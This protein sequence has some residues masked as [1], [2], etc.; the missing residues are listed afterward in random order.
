MA[1]VFGNTVC[2]E[3]CPVCINVLP[4]AESLTPNSNIPLEASLALHQGGRTGRV[5]SG[6]HIRSVTAIFG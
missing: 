3:R 5:V 6:H 1:V 2:T 4:I